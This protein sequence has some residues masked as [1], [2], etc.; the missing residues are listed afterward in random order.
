MAYNTKIVPHENSFVGL[1]FQDND[2]VYTTDTSNEVSKLQ[3]ELTTK[4]KELTQNV[5]KATP[6][7]APNTLRTSNVGERKPN[8]GYKNL[9]PAPEQRSNTLFIRQPIPEPKT[10]RR[11]C[12]RG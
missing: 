5:V 3:E 7:L 12:G 2:L 11:C 6:K 10:P 8:N 9:S 1:I 4:L